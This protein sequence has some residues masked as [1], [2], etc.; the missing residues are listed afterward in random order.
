[1]M[2]TVI[3]LLLLAAGIGA[4]LRFWPS[5]GK[6]ASKEEQKDYK[7]RAAN[8]IDGKFVNDG[9]F[10]LMK[11]DSNKARNNVV[12]QSATVPK[13]GLP[14]CKPKLDDLGDTSDVTVT[15]L[16]HSTVLLQMD[17]KNLLLDPVFSKFASPVSFAGP[18]RFSDFAMT[19]D[20]LPRIDLVLISHDHY[21]HLDYATIQAIDHKVAQYIVPLG[22]DKHL[23]RWKVDKSKLINLAWWEEIS[24]EGFIIACTPTRHFSGRSITDQ[25]KS[26]WCSWVIKNASSKLFASGD[27]GYGTHF[28]E[29]N[30]RYGAFDLAIME[31]GQYD[32]AWPQVHMTP[33]ETYQA[34]CDLE[35][36]VIVPIHWGA[37]KLAKHPWDDPA[38][39][40]LLA[41]GENENH[42]ITPMIGETVELADYSSHMHRWWKD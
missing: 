8:Y 31:C 26:L 11:R 4:F 39:R 24:I 38:E 35:A 2:N 41:A 15:W 7:R 6:T 27:G 29:I 16:G 22:V 33:E 28:K 32:V 20:Q 12:S 10:S 5:F 14:V 36:D 42:V 1:M 23:E 25:S 37:Y 21:D 18:K 3:I 17:G 13:G 34:A 30:N 19:V 9:E 40:I